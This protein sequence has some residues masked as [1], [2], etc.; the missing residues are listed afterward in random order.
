MEIRNRTKRRGLF[1]PRYVD[2]ILNRH[3]RGLPDTPFGRLRALKIW[4]LLSVELWCRTFI[5]QVPDLPAR[6][7]I[8]RRTEQAGG[9]T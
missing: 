5:D 3:F 7:N 6:W 2:R 8:P 1:N 4:Q 9:N